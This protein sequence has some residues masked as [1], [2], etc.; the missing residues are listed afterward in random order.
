LAVADPSA[1]PAAIARM[2]G[3][4]VAPTKTQAEDWL[5]MLQAACAGG[6]KSD[7]GQMVALELYA[8]TLTRYPADVAREACQALALKERDGA[9]W[10]PT[11]AEINSEC[12]RRTTP[13]QT[14]L[15]A[16]KSWR[17]PTEADRLRGEAYDLRYA[18]AEANAEITRVRR[19]DPDRAS[20]LAE[21]METARAQATELE[22]QARREEE[23][24]G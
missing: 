19:S 12:E 21:F 11:L 14:M 10:F 24:R 5:V 16:L 23:A 20:E 17:A 7:V 1:I 6:R 9:T 13:R 2:E 18:A 4:L 22:R 3:S 8:G 15:H